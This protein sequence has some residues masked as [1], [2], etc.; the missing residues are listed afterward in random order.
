MSPHTRS[1][2]TQ[3]HS[4]NSSHMHGYFLHPQFKMQAKGSTST[5]QDAPKDN[6]SGEGPKCRLPQW[7][8]ANCEAFITI[9]IILG[10][11]VYLHVLELSLNS[12]CPTPTITEVEQG[13]TFVIPDI[14]VLCGQERD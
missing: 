11:T 14:N 8:R 6:N 9:T 7:L 10:Y 5:L 4:H 12:A 1:K 3:Y 2:Y 13:F